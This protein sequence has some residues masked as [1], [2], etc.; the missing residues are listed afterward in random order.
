MKQTPSEKDIPLDNE[1]LSNSDAARRA[2]DFYLNPSPPAE[3]AQTSWL[4]PREGLNE[5]QTTEHATQLLRWAAATAHE[6]AN[7]LQGTQRD[8][9]LAVVHM[10]NT[11]RTVLEHMPTHQRP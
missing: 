11:A 3:P 10:I 2:L 8:L 6:S 5:A 9:A 7:G 4:V 1:S